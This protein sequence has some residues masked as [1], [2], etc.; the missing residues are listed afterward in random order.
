VPSADWSDGAGD[1]HSRAVTQPDWFPL[2]QCALA[3]GDAAA[4]VAVPKTDLH[5]HG[6]LS[7]PPS[8]YAEIFGRPVPA[9]PSRFDDFTAFTAY[10]VGELA[11]ALRSPAAVRRLVRAAFARLRDDGVVYA[12]MSFDLLLPNAIGLSVGQ[13]AALLAEEAA[14]VAPQVVV[15]PE[16]GVN[17]VVPADYAASLAREWIDTGVFKSID[18]YGDEA[19]GDACD[20]APLYRYAADRGLKR[21]AHAGELCDAMAMRAA[22]AAL[23][24]DAIHHGVRAAEDPHLV[25]Q[26]A[27]RGI[28]LHICPTSNL[29]L[30]VAPSFDAHPAR[31]LHDAG[32]AL[33][34]NTDDLTIFGANSCDEILNL[35]RMGFAAEDVAAIIQ[36]GLAEAR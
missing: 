23:E 5:C 20:F 30:R 2:L 6:L 3:D 11:P 21:K 35:A 25:E 15:A 29:A 17:R 19:L 16:V 22:L 12:E 14:L 36:R 4:L 10:I 28:A 1:G 9:P 32:V 34:V 26:L 31:A 8:A 7:V 33:T 13:F 27:T 24:P 18:L